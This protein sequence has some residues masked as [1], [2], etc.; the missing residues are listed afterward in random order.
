MR[1][2]TKILVK[3]L[4]T[5]ILLSIFLPV[6]IS[7]LLHVGCVQNFVVDRAAEFASEYLGARVSIG[8]IDLRL[9][10]T[11]NVEDFYVE[12]Y[13]RDTLIYARTAQTRISSLNIVQDGLRLSASRAEGAKV[14]IRELPSG[15][16]NIRPIVQRLQSPNPKGNFRLFMDDIEADNVVFAYE[17]LEH[18]NPEYGMDYFDMRIENIS[19]RVSSL[20]VVKGRVDIGVER[21]SAREK[22][23]IT[24][25]NLTSNLWIDRG[26]IC[27]EDFSLVTPNSSLVI[28]EFS[29]LGDNWDEYKDFIN[30]VRMVGNVADVTLSTEDLGYFAPALK[31]WNVVVHHGVA[32]LDGVVSDFEVELES[33]KLGN[34]STVSATCHIVGMPD[35]QRSKYVVGLRNM[36]STSEDILS[37]LENVVKKPLS[38]EVYSIIDRAEWIDVRGTFGGRLNNFRVIGNLNSERG[39]ISTDVTLSK[40]NDG[41]ALEGHVKSSHLDLGRLL[42]VGLLH[43][44]DARVDFKGSAETMS[45]DDINAEL[46]LQIDSFGVGDYAYSDISATGLMEN[47]QYYSEVSSEDENMR[48]MLYAMA[49]RREDVPHYGLS[50]N[51][52]HADLHAVGINRRDSISELSTSMGIDLV[53]RGLDDFEGFASIAD[54]DY[55]YPQGELSTGRMH[56][57]VRGGDEL[58]TLHLESDFFDM[59]YQSRSKYSEVIDYLTNALKHYVPLLYDEHAEGGK[60]SQTVNYADDYT[61]LK[62]TTHEDA[63]MLFDAIVGG[64]VMAPDTQATMMLNPGT[65]LLSLQASSETLEYAGVLMANY[66]LDINNRSDSLSMW[67]NSSCIYLGSRPIMPNFSLTGGAQR[68]RITLSAGFRD[69]SDFESGLFGIRAQFKRN[70]QTRR[71]SVHI[72]LTPSHYTTSTQ[73]WRLLSRG[74]DIDSTHVNIRNFMLTRPGQRLVING[75]ASRERTDSMRVTLENFDLS[76]LSAITSRVG[77]NFVGRSNGYAMVKSALHAPEIEAHIDLDSLSVNDIAIPEQLLTSNWDFEENRARIIICNPERTDTA[78]RGYYQPTSNRYY[79][80]ANMRGV[81]LDLISPFLKGILSDIDGEADIEATVRGQGRNAKLNGRAV[82]DSL[83]VTVDYL[84]TRYS[85]PVAEVNIVDNHIIADSVA[86][87]DSEG[88]EGHFSIDLNLQNLSNLVYDIGIDIKD[89]LVLNTTE[90]NNDLFYGHVYASG[91]AM[92]HGDKLGMKIDIDATS[93][94]NSTFFMPLTGKSDISTADFVTF[95]SKVGDQRDTTAFLTRRMMAHE[96][97]QRQV[98]SSE[99]VMDV[100]MLLNVSPNTEIQLVIDPT[101]GDIIKAKG[102]GQLSVHIVPKANVFEM[103][104]DYTITE[105]TYLFTLQNILNKR[106]TVKPNSSIHWSGDPLGAIL[107]IDAVYSTKASLQ[108]LLGSSMQGIDVSRAVPVDCYIKLTDKLMSPTVTFD[109]QVPNVAPEI[110]T[111]IQSTLND[112]QAISTQ[113]V[114]LLAANSFAA[115]DAG[116]MGATLTATTGFELLSNQLSNWLSG[117]NYNLTVRYRPRTEYTGDEVDVGFSKGWLN[118]RLIVEVE[119][120]YL[121]D[122]SVQSRQNASNFVGEAFV[123]WVI[124]PDGT[125]RL[126]GFTQTID[127]YGENQGMQETGLGFYYGESFNTFADLLDALRNRFSNKERKARRAERK[128]AK[129]AEAQKSAAADTLRVEASVIDDDDDIVEEEMLE[130]DEVIVLQPKAKAESDKRNERV[131]K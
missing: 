43:G 90:K 93:G 58:R 75:V 76:P 115:E 29:L 102:N 128:A 112:Q 53:G 114:W 106:F 50:I 113:M 48:F 89:M 5:I 69:K 45:L 100:D 21:L 111:I 30:N 36:H 119:G 118:N 96:R 47:G 7:L 22:C 65:N 81:K 32:S 109:V 73:Q 88:N 26:V 98:S 6:A 40:P 108:P 105:G 15:E 84:N 77:Y 35:W 126:K 54:V 70:E 37:I 123:T 68:N 125:F 39:A 2:V 83:A 38:E 24:I 19:A 11:V 95:T 42:D 86:V 117:D 1:K 74:I 44:L 67:L 122:A 120:G 91:S 63:N 49:D 41:L 51:L 12:D 57:D 33:A 16:L 121:S 127:R 52:E 23:G 10:S 59:Q 14:Y 17:R 104:G 4:S 101:V 62:I 34:S 131:N 99:G 85:A 66:K 72:D 60:E 92:F 97:K 13:N 3:V 25:D 78:I 116:A 82:A 64:L 56:L 124:D 20:S 31:D 80:R 107:N 71:R 46:N 8:R 28:P 103:R 94:D 18:R 61:I 79:A 129:M 110:Q 130:E 87:Y 55:K 9:L 27:F